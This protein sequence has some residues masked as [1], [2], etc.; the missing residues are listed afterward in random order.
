MCHLWYDIELQD[1]V[2]Y[3]GWIEK[4]KKKKNTTYVVAYWKPK[5]TY[6][7]AVDFDMCKF[8]LGADVVC[9]DLM[10]S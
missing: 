7:D 1:H 8:Q 10:L 5:E 9:G 6:D 3:Y 4:L 2:L